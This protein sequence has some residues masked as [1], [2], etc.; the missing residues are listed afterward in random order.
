MKNTK[1]LII[2]FFM[3]SLTF[4]VDTKAAGPMDP[5]IYFNGGKYVEIVQG[6]AY[7]E[8]G[9]FAIDSVDGIIDEYEVLGEVDVITPGQYVLSYKVTDSDG[10]VAT[11]SRL[12][13]VTPFGQELD[14]TPQDIFSVGEILNWGGD[15][16][17]KIT[18]STETLDGGFVIV[19]QV[20]TSDVVGNPIADYIG[21]ENNNPSLGDLSNIIVK[22]NSDYK[23]VWAEIFGSVLKDRINEIIEISSDEFVFV[24]NTG[25]YGNGNTN[26][27]YQGVTILNANGDENNNDGMDAILGKFQHNGSNIVTDWVS[28]VAVSGITNISNKQLSDV[29]LDSDGNIVVAGSRVQNQNTL[30]RVFIQ[31]Y[32]QEGS[33]IA[34]YYDPTIGNDHRSING[35]LLETSDG[36]VLFTFPDVEISDIVDYHPTSNLTTENASARAIRLNDDLDTEIW[37]EAIDRMSVRDAIIT[38]DG[39]IVVVGDDFSTTEIGTYSNTIN[40]PSTEPTHYLQQYSTSLMIKLDISDGLRVWG[41]YVGGDNYDTLSNNSSYESYSNYD[42]RIFSIEQDSGDNYIL[43][44]K[45]RSEGSHETD[46]SNP[47]SDSYSI[48]AVSFTDDTIGDTVSFTSNI[49]L[50]SNLSA[51]YDSVLKVGSKY[52]AT[53]YSEGQYG[54]SMRDNDDY[55]SNNEN[56]VFIVELELINSNDVEFSAPVV[57]TSITID[58]DLA[59]N[60]VEDLID[61]S[62]GSIEV[63]SDIDV[64]FAGS[65]TY[66]FDETDFDHT[67]PGV[68]TVPYY[69][70]D[71]DKNAASGDLIITINDITAPILIFESLDVEVGDNPDFL[72]GVTITDEGDDTLT[73]NDIIVDEADFDEDVLGKYDI[74][75]TITDSFGNERVVT[76]RV[77]VVDEIGLVIEFE[78]DLVIEVGTLLPN[79]LEG[80]DLSGNR[81]VDV[82]LTDVSVNTAP[83]NL[84]EVGIY[85]VKYTVDNGNQEGDATRFVRVVDTQ[86]PVFSLNNDKSTT[87]PVDSSEPNWL[88]YV[89]VEDSYDNNPEV[90]YITDIQ[91]HITGSYSV[92]FTARDNEGNESYYELPVIIGDGIAPA[93]ELKGEMEVSVEVFTSYEEMGYILSDN[94]DNSDDIIVEIVDEIIYTNGSVDTVGT[95][96]IKY[97]AIDLSGNRSETIERIVHIVDIT[98]PTIEGIEFK[99]AVRTEDIDFLEGII[100]KDNYD[101]E[102]E[103]KPEDITRVADL[104]KPNGNYIVTITARDSS[105]NATSYSYGLY[106]VNE[107]AQVSSYIMGAAV[108]IL[109]GGGI[110]M[111]TRKQ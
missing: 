19:V 55:N 31:N 92:V 12:V 40:S 21:I 86:G 46:S 84:L 75:L 44:G 67:I 101:N 78:G 26:S 11:D 88:E 62:T 3:L 10:N 74:T 59:I 8:Q 96:R 70:Y 108:V 50:H 41:Y 1:R 39:N 56:D 72:E 58:E 111:A 83:I 42:D 45:S 13:V 82:S 89:D 109:L 105:G 33:L 9:V 36:Y 66:V 77:E 6:G 97:T 48:W 110:L 38:T 15:S 29:I 47:Y 80:V 85:E 91:Y 73:L 60:D 53:Y 93:I 23:V 22:Y 68:Y 18:A 94:Y 106:I 90:S 35:S 100:I 57:E 61:D 76:R 95:Y 54:I 20:E 71:N 37:N 24:G 34:E 98:A 5:V 28:N 81:G 43:F 32:S 4:L 27:A 14:T 25:Y 16:N 2:L 64:V 52:L 102:I 49:T 7:I 17:D 65:L 69:M 51:N 30:D 99:E 103:V 79:Y 87:I 104:S 63:D 107:D